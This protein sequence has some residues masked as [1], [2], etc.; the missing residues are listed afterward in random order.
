MSFDPAVHAP[1]ALGA[2]LPELAMR[3]AVALVA[4]VLGHSMRASG[5]V[6]TM[7]LVLAVR[8]SLLDL[9]LVRGWIRTSTASGTTGPAKALGAQLLPQ[10]PMPDE[11]T[12]WGWLLCSSRG[13]AILPDAIRCD[14]CRQVGSADVFHWWIYHL[15]VRSCLLITSS[16]ACFNDCLEPLPLLARTCRRY[17]VVHP[18]LEVLDVSAYPLNGRLYA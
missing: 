10:L 13:K 6:A 14:Q 17:Y 8:A 2:I 5:T 15:L 18:L 1:S 12:R 4:T 9:V 3:T 11:A 16:C 7:G